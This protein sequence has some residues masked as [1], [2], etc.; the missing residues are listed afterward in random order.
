MLL[1]YEYQGGYNK[2]QKN[3]FLKNV[4]PL[5]ENL[6]TDGLIALVVI[7]LYFLNK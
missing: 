2:A 5:T 6:I 7:I 3:V 1:P 4:S